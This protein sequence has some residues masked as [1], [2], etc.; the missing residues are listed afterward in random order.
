MMKEKQNE[1][2]GCVTEDWGK[3]DEDRA[4]SVPTRPRNRYS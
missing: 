4:K 1:K 2:T 3:I